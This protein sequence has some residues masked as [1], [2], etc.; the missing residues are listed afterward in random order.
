MTKKHHPTN[1]RIK[2]EYFEFLREAKRHDESTVDAAAKA[3]HLFEEYN[4]YKDFKA[5]HYDQAVGF[6]K[7]L[8]ERKA[9]RSGERLSKATIYATLQAL[10]RFFEWLALQPGY[11]SRVQ[12][13]DAAYFHLSEKD[14]RIATA[15]REPRVPTLEQ[16]KSVLVSMPGNNEIELRNRALIAFTLLTGARDSAI[17]SAKL[18]HLDLVQG[19][20]KQDARDVKTKFSK[21]FVTYFLSRGR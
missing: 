9:I 11:K 13:T 1:E 2:R 18:K 4:R 20:S 7:S 12:F 19:C 14:T 15:R 8:A 10:K 5:F 6:K 17:A 3:I 16:I 21:T